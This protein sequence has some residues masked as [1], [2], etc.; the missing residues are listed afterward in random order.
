[1]LTLTTSLI[2]TVLAAAGPAEIASPGAG[3]EEVVGD[4]VAGQ[5]V[6]C[7]DM[8]RVQGTRIIKDTAIIYDAGRTVYVNRPRGGAE[9]LDKWDVMVTKTAGRQLCSID[10]VELRDSSSQMMTGLVF[11]GDF[12]PYRKPKAD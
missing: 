7:I 5:P 12:V 1:M 8:H 2:L 3:I 9:G 10:V 11:L 4:R 6:S